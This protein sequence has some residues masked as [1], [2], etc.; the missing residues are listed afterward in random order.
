[1][2]TTEATRSVSALLRYHARAWANHAALNLGSALRSLCHVALPPQVDHSR[3]TVAELS[4][5]TL[6]QEFLC[7]LGVKTRPEAE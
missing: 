1:M 5:S 7:G 6:R 3:E 2:S 4:A